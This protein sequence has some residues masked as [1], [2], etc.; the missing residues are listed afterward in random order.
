MTLRRRMRALPLSQIRLTDSFWTRYQRVLIEET[1]PAEY[2]QIVATSRLANFHRVTGKAEGTHEGIYFN[3]SDVYKYVEACA[4]GLAVGERLASKEA[5][6]RV[7]RQMDEAIDS[8]VAAQDPDGYINTFFQLKHPTLKW[9]NL[10]ML[11][12]M[13]CGGHLIEAGVACFQALG[14]RRLLDV[15]IR[16]ADHVMSIF[17]PNGRPGYCGHQEIELAL[18]RLA[19]ATADKKYRE[20]ARWMVEERGKSPSVFLRELDDEGAMTLN[21]GLRHHL[22]KDGRY[23]GEYAQ[24]HA[25]IREHTEVVGHAVR[26]MYFY[27]AAADL[28]D[29][30]G[31]EELELA[32]ERI[33]NN[34]TH[35]R[36]YVTGGIGPS[37]KNEGFTGDYDLPNLTAYAETCAS[38]GLIFWGQKM[39]E[40]TGN[41]EYADIVER[42][43][44]NGAISGISLDGRAFFY[45]N[46][47][48]SRGQ[49]QR[50]PWFGCACCPPNI[51]RLLG[52]LGHYVASV[53]EG[54]FF[55]HIAAG[56]EAECTFNGVATR[57]R[58]ESNYPWSGEVKIHVEPER[59]VRF[60]LHVRIPDW[61]EEVGT[62]LPRA[63]EEATYETGYA[64]F[65]RTWKA[66]EVLTVDL[67]VKPKWVESD[68]RVRDNLGRAA[69]TFG[70]LV[71]CAE[72][73]DL[74]YA[75]QLFTADTEMEMVEAKEK[76]LEGV[77]TL[78]VEGTYDV[79]LFTDS[80]YADVGTTEVREGSA[81]FVPYYAWCNRGA[82]N[83]QVWVRKL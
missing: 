53:S 33:W 79:E 64:V 11:H 9:R 35:K 78:T 28:A 6:D 30:Q 1:L 26:A 3:D 12:E 55:L 52:A 45:D 77:T 51:A 76:I 25:P 62:D 63:E 31:D 83:M 38:V 37:S 20:F 4:Y 72:Q 5:C 17:G 60:A 47:L 13:Y 21:P 16:F 43:L 10:S 18:V 14:D 46:P 82:T 36:M 41:G 61:S 48:E 34:L 59:P 40:L 73:H 23:Q 15:S 22:M 54:A 57:I 68:P 74:G 75:P 80:L 66:A 29:G 81:K 58:V 50:V 71:Y 69:L 2:D 8:V 44:Y 39:L 49:H 67:G 42:A 7:R 19:D 24:D 70:P 27:I 56:L 65:D 32:L